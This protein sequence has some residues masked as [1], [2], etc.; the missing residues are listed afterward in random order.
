MR[1][2]KMYGS[3]AVA[4]LV[5]TVALGAVSASA[6]NWDPPNVQ[7]AGSG[8]LTLTTNTGASVSCTATVRTIA[9]PASDLATTVNSGGAAAGPVFDTCTTSLAPGVHGLVSVDAPGAWRA[10][11]TSTTT[12]DVTA[13]GVTIT[14]GSLCTIHVGDVNVPNNTWSNASHAL[15]ANS[16]ASFPVTETGFLCDGGVTGRMAGTVTFPASAIIT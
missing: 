8:A 5:T 9:G 13:P 4:A 2:L 14:I 1:S 7:Q 6:A 10:T 3:A 16:G 12:V 15:T 11:A